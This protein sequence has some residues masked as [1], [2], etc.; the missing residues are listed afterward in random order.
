MRGLHSGEAGKNP[1]G[2]TV[3]YLSGNPSFSGGVGHGFL[4]SSLQEGFLLVFDQIRD[5]TSGS[6]FDKG[7]FKEIVK[8]NETD[9]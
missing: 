8:M 1:L 5:P 3:R 9:Y 7:L 2:H 4:Y 6:A